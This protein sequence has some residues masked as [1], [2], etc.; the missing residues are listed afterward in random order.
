MS[1]R[2]KWNQLP[3]ALVHSIEEFFGAR[4]EAAHEVRGG[5]SRIARFRLDFAERPSVFLKGDYPGNTAKGREAF[6]AELLNYQSFPEL[7]A[8]APRYLGT[9]KDSEWQVMFLQWM[10]EAEPVPPWRE[11]AAS[12]VIKAVVGLHQVPENRMFKVSPHFRFEPMRLWATLFDDEHAFRSFLGLF[13]EPRGAGHWLNSHRDQILKLEEKA[14]TFCFENAPIHLDLRSDNFLIS[15]TNKVW[16]VD[17]SYLTMG[18]RCLDLSYW[19][20]SLSYES[21][22][23]QERVIS[24]YEAAYGKAFAKEEVQICAVL[25]AGFFG[26]HAHQPDLPGMPELRTVQKKQ[27]FPALEWLKKVLKNG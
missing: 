1:M 4:I 27:F 17:W 25:V 10:S 23:P 18:P 19:L 21:G 2:P 14:A 3:G 26:F 16:L 12:A 24:E 8:F 5:Y 11:G 9:L 20:P 6:V 7:A 13:S 22:L 15:R